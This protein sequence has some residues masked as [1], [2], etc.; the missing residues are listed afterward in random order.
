MT[1][2][3]DAEGRYCLNDL[4][5]VATLGRNP[6]TVEVHEYIR[7]PETQ[8]LIKELN[9]GNPR[10]IPVESLRGRYGGTFVVKE[11]VY[12]YA[13]WISPAFHSKV[14]RA[15]DTLQTQGVAVAERA[16]ADFLKKLVPFVEVLLN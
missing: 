8:D 9:T 13:M 5:K 16:A 14:V 4:Q 7:R 2:R 10:I 12:T 15:F 1:I 11:L 6:R 3:Q